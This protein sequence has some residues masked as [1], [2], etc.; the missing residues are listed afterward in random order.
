[1]EELRKE[2]EKEQERQEEM[3]ANKKAIMGRSDLKSE[4]GQ[5]SAK[6]A[7]VSSLR[8]PSTSAG[9]SGLNV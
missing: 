8:I 2:R 6:S 1:M 4:T 5:A 9:S 3:R 7:G